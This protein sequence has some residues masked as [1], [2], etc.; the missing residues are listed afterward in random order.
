MRV[1]FS[2]IPGISHL[3][4]LV[5]L[6]WA[7]R[8][9]GHEV[10]LAFGEYTDKAATTGLEV[11]DVAPGYDGMRLIE[12]TL[13]ADPELAERFW[14][15]SLSDDPTPWAPLFAA[16][17]RPLIEETMN[18]VDQWRPDLVVYEQ[19]ATVGLLAA[20]RA[21]VPAVQRNMGIVRTGEMHEATVVHLADLMERYGIAA[22][23]TPDRVLEYVPPSMLPH[24]EPE[25]WFMREVPYT[26]GGVLGDRLPEQPTKRRVVI[27]MGT[28][29][30]GSDFYGLEPVKK[31]ITAAST[32][33]A[34]FLLALGHVD[35]TPL[36]ELPANVRSIGWAPLAALFRTCAGVIHHGG[37][38]T[39]MAA[40]EAGIPQLL[41]LDPL[42]Q[43]NET[44]GPAVR[45][46]GIGIVTTLE[47]IESSM[48]EQM[49]T[50]DT[51][52]QA[53]LRVRDEL[54]TLPSPAD[55][56]ARLIDELVPAA[57]AAA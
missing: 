24:D 29:R 38:G 20:A 6:A 26:G 31:I 45:Q 7:F 2:S 32:V 4:A 34:E 53:T 50:D 44:T 15:E 39:T 54:A 17:N 22:V 8:A 55:V 12:Q 10:V 33:D 35:I 27:T 23:P 11:V 42:D 41:A 52:R 43:G 18:I 30:P 48:I 47:E 51:Y 28:V 14:S 36:G 56:A 9:N 16:I 1:L 3:F 46:G 57:R 37:G 49:L 19:A 13:E 21:G 40:I 5:P 25:G